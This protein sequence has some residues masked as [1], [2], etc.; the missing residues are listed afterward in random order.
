MKYCEYAQYEIH[1]SLQL[2]IM[3]FFYFIFFYFYLFIFLLDFSLSISLSLWRHLQSVIT[4]EGGDGLYIFFLLIIWLFGSFNCIN[5][6]L[7]FGYFHLHIYSFSSRLSGLKYTRTLTG[8]LTV[9]LTAVLTSI[10]ASI[11]QWNFYC[12][13]LLDFPR[14]APGL[15][16]VS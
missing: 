3:F 10:L 12:C 1:N 6:G 2:C 8:I 13:S 5:F 11:S 15:L 16:F 14:F 9:V 4:V 7:V